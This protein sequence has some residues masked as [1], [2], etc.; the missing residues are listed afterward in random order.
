M[1]TGEQ[2]EQQLQEEETQQPIEDLEEEKNL[3]QEG[4]KIKYYEWDQSKT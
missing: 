1:P 3:N 4:S 2:L